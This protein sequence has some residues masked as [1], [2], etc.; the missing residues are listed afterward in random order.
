MNEARSARG[1]QHHVSPER[2][3]PIRTGRAPVLVGE[4]PEGKGK[5]KRAKG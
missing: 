5:V 3:N 1:D 2:K 4:N